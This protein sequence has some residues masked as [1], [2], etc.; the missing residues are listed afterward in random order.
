MRHPGRAIALAAIAVVLLTGCS[1]S[2]SF[3]LLLTV[4]NAADGTPLPE[5]TAVLDTGTLAEE[6]KGDPDEGS[7]LAPT[8]DAGQLTFDFNSAGY[9]STTGPWYLKVRKEGFEPQVIDVSPHVEVKSGGK[10]RHPL[11]V[12]IRLKPLPKNL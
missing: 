7:L 3:R 12:T 8:N 4:E 10:E 2:C 6:R 9:T 11:P 5:A 1:W